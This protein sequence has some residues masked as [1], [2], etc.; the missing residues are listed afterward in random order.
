[1]TAKLKGV[2]IPYM[3]TPHN[4]E[5]ARARL[6]RSFE[7]PDEDRQMWEK[8]IAEELD[9]LEATI[10]GKAPVPELRGKLPIVLYFDTD[11][12]REE[13]VQMV[14]AIKGEEGW[15]ERKLPPAV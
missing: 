1:M 9:A 11:E 6:A 4:T 5:R 7:L 13:F 3:S 14:R 12:D 8:V 15:T 10:L 2:Y